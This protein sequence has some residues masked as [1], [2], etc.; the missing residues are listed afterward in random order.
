MKIRKASKEDVPG[1]LPVWRELMEMHALLDPFFT[2]REDGEQAFCQFVTDNI[3]EPNTRVLVAEANGRVIGYCQGRVEKYPPVLETVEFGQ[4]LDFA[5]LE[6]CRR[7][8][9]GQQML[10]KMLEWF[11]S[12]GL[13]RIEVRCSVH[14]E[15]SRSFWRKMGF[16]PVM[17]TLFRSFPKRLGPTGKEKHENP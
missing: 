7:Q 16:Q 10:E 1:I 15:V 12:R 17:E 14:N 13:L 5:V 8:G 3:R 6:A 2:F 9:A 4:I 11:W